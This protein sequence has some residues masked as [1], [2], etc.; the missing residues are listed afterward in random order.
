MV[1]ANGCGPVNE[2]VTISVNPA[3]S[4][5]TSPNQMICPGGT[6]GISALATGGGGAPYT[7]TWTNSV[8]TGT[9]V[10]Q[11]G[12]VSPTANAIYTVTVTDACGT[13]AASDTMMVNLYNLPAVAYSVDT[14][15]GC[16]PVV[17]FFN[18]MT[19]NTASCVWDFGDGTTSTNLNP[20]HVFTDPGCYDIGLTVTTSDGC[21]VDTLIGNQI[22]V[23]A[24]PVAEFSFAPVPADVLDPQIVFTNLSINGS[25]YNWDFGGLG[26]S[27]LTNPTF[28]F[29]AD[30]GGVYTVCMSTITDNGCADSICHEVTILDQFLIYVPNAFT[31]DGDG[32]NDMFMP[33]L[34]GENPL[35]YEFYIF[36]R[37]GEVIFQSNNLL[38]GWDGTHN[39]VKVKEDVYVWKIKVK[40]KINQDKMEFHGHVNLLR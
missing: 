23:Y 17:V 6:A 39:G 13:P 35:T 27:Q 19:A 29:P 4:V 33:R 32:V 5:E 25:T 11:S 28:T 37:W 1:D 22:C 15:K 12:N 24:V 2:S 26:N 10:S 7:Y 31:P 21:V 30:S 40:K 8:T 36:N 38:I 3:L 14:T 16:E 20:Q 34:Q 9:L 18:N